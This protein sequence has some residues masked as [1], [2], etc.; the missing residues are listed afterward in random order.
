MHCL[1]KYLSKRIESV[2]KL[3]WEESL[4][5]SMM[6]S[7]VDPIASAEVP[8]IHTGDCVGLFEIGCPV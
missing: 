2:A 5:S 3:V 1:N 6:A 8:M 7:A 4:A